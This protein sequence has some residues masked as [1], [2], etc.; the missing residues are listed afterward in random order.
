MDLEAFR[1]TGPEFVI[2]HICGLFPLEGSQLT[3]VG[4]ISEVRAYP[5]VYVGGI[6]TSGIDVDG[7]KILAVASRHKLSDEGFECYGFPHKFCVCSGSSR[8]PNT[9]E[10][11]K[12]FHVPGSKSEVAVP[13]MVE[14]EDGAISRHMGAVGVEEGGDM[15]GI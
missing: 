14:A 7:S 3:R 9:L 4:A 1:P 15:V 10:I 2:E 11:P 8:V 12:V 13:I 5:L 6:E